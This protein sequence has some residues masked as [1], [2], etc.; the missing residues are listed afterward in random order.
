MRLANWQPDGVRRLSLPHR[1]DFFEAL[2]FDRPAD[3]RKL[4]NIADSVVVFD[5]AQSLPVNLTTSTL[6]AVNELC[7]RYH[8]TMVFSTATQPDFAARKDLDWTPREIIPE[9]KEIFSALR[10]TEIEWRLDRKKYRWRQSRRKCLR[11]TA[12]VLLSTCVAMRGRFADA[13]YQS[14]P[15]N[16]VF[17]LTTDL[18]PAHRSRQIEIIRQ[19]LHEGKPMSWWRRSALKREWIWTSKRYIALWRLWMPSFRRPDGATQTD[20]TRWDE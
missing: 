11:W 20:V 18:C 4:H 2:F 10:R 8:T 5:E 12:Y 13:L 19:R 6:R 3:C 16:T 15:K 7:S 9:N 1:F 14:C 17:F